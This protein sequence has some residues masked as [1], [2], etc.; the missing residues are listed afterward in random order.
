M[1][2][3]KLPKA[4]T[5]TAA[6]MRGADVAVE[7]VEPLAP[8]ASPGD[9]RERAEPA[10]AAPS[11]G[12]PPDLASSAAQHAPAE[13]AV[14]PAN[15]VIRQATDAARRRR[16]AE[17]IVERYA[18]FSALGGVIPLPVINFAGVATIIIR[19]VKA[20]S[21]L[22]GVPFEQDRARAIVLGLIGGL[23]PTAASTLTASTLLY[24]IPG[25][26][27]VGLAA[28]SVTASACARKIGSVFIDHFESGASLAD[29]PAI[30]NR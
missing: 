2:K 8:S 20:L 1:N 4:I 10:V 29:F 6:D 21:R 17:A 25:S 5:R 22:Y 7:P 23:T 15:T 16:R 24:V 28:A 11:A 27:L 14:V 13:V 9:S 3:K 18:N 30:A 26:N 12:S 19:M